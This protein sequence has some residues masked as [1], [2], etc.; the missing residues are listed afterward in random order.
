M[1]AANVFGPSDDWLSQLSLDGIVAVADVL[2]VEEV[3]GLLAHLEPI[4]GV[5]AGDRR[6]YEDAVI[7]EL[8]AAGPPAKLAMSV[9]GSARVVRILYFDKSPEANWTVPY[10][11]DLT[12]AARER[13][14]L[15][16]FGPWSVKA[17]T[18]HVRAARAVL[19]GMIAVR[20][21]LDDCGLEN[22]PPGQSA[23]YEQSRVLTSP[24][25]F[26]RASWMMRL[27]EDTRRLMLRRSGVR[28]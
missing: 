4:V 16:G 13:M 3:S 26:A 18:P 9:V 20:L 28:F 11:Q 1:A 21:H 10:H 8:A 23:R 22:G 27:R 5:G 17:G 14:E 15:A 2:S 12:I 19:E 6:L 7:R 25:C 24:A